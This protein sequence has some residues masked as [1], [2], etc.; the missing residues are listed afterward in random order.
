MTHNNELLS[1]KIFIMPIA[2]YICCFCNFLLPFTC[3]LPFL[4]PLLSPFLHVLLFA[5]NSFLAFVPGCCKLLYFHCAL[6]KMELNKF[7]CLSAIYCDCNKT[8]ENYVP[9]T[10][11]F[12]GSDH[13]VVHNVISGLLHTS[14][15]SI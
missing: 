8:D 7:D 3:L 2:C 12:L 4:P 6:C 9:Q 10:K 11:N 15:N 1:F 14:Q 5:F 13:T